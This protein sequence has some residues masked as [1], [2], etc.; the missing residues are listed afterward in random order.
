MRSRRGEVPFV[1]I[2]VGRSNDP[3]EVLGLARDLGCSRATALGYVALWE[4]LILE[5]GDAT[6]GKIKGYS[7]PHI[8]AKLDW[9]GKP[10]RLLEALRRAG[11]LA[12]HRGVFSHAYWTS[13]VTGQ[14]A[15]DRAE[16][17][18]HWRLQKQQQRAQD[19]PKDVRETSD[20]VR[21]TSSRTADIKKER[22]D[23]GASPPPDPPQAGG[24]LG[25]SRWRW[26]R[27]NHKRPSGERLCLR[28]LEAMSED[29]WALIQWLAKLPAGGGGL[30]PPWKKRV[31]K[32]NTHQ[33]IA[34]QAY[35]E[36]L[37]EWG[38]KLRQDRRPPRGAPAAVAAAASS[39][40]S[41]EAKRLADS[42]AF[43]LTALADPTLSDS[44]KE[45]HRTR[46]VKAHPGEPAPWEAPPQAEPLQNN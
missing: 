20:D 12:S 9:P 13:S 8:A 1:A 7:A 23:N 4:E 26:L 34:K 40:R 43:V 28:Y 29:D 30:I 19:V 36:I 27:E 18:E 37:P 35:L 41:E 2:R 45:A 25:A 32:L 6:T 22:K 10:A 46:W 21:E 33:L 38:E 5:V 31:L 44:D 17:R 39:D 14:Y 42:I 24:A 3:R 11:L 16:Q 15:S